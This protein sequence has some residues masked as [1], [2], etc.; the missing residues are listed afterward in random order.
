MVTID[1]Y[2]NDKMYPRITRAV[3]KIL[4]KGKIVAPVDVLVEMG[5]L[6]SKHIE[7]W[8]RVP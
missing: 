3:G 5:L 1:S 6:N 4:A 7:P 8:L 2:R